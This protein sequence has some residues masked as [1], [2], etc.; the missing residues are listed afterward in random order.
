MKFIT[1]EH[2][3]GEVTVPLDRLISVSHH[4]IH[5]DNEFYYSIDE[6]GTI[7]RGSLTEDQ[8]NKLLKQLN[9]IDKPM[10]DYDIFSKVNNLTDEQIELLN[11]VMDEKKNASE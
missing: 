4:K 8:Y 3:S 2:M 5:K 10:T 7:D 9:N 11:N 6:C 1:I